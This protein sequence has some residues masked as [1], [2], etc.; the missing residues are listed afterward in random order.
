MQGVIF[1]DHLRPQNNTQG[2]SPFPAAPQLITGDRVKAAVRTESDRK[3]AAGH[4]HGVWGILEG[5][6]DL[7]SKV[8]SRL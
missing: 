1:Y 3:P 7:V 8:I 5:S 2:R 4:I 6:W